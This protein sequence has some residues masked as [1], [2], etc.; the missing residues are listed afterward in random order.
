[1]ENPYDP[2]STNP[3][4][5]QVKVKVK[6]IVDP[7]TYAYKLIELATDATSEPPVHYYDNKTVELEDNITIALPLDSADSI[8]VYH[9]NGVW[10]YKFVYSTTVVAAP[11][12]PFDASICVLQVEVQ[13][14]GHDPTSHSIGKEGKAECVLEGYSHTLE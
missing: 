7:D 5:T 14:T 6:T 2:G 10:T 8:E 13:E 11:L 4:I 1:M 12:P 3:K 9:D